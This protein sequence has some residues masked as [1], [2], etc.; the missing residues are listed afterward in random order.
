[1]RHK[2][3]TILLRIRARGH[4]VMSITKYHES[5]YVGVLDNPHSY[6][7]N[8]NEDDVIMMKRL[9]KEAKT[10]VG[11]RLIQPLYHA[12]RPKGQLFMG[13][14]ARYDDASVT[15]IQVVETPVTNN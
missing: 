12:E 4:F 2:T 6:N 13:A 7:D 1:M 15:S 3:V 10:K 5:H 8:D 14:N 11:T 9:T